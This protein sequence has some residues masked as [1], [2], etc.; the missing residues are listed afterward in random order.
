MTFEKHK[1]YRVQKHCKECLHVLVI[2][3][4]ADDLLYCHK[5]K[6]KRPPCPWGIFDTTANRPIAREA[7]DRIRK[8]E[9]EEWATWAE[10]RKVEAAGYCDDYKYRSGPYKVKSVGPDWG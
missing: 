6:A 8:R 3:T 5:D 9:M 4:D 10:P 7:R 2:V 1:S